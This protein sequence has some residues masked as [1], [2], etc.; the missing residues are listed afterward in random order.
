MQVPSM[1]VSKR[2][3][4]SWASCGVIFLPRKL[5]TCGLHR[6]HRSAGKLFIQG[7][8]GLGGAKDKIEGIFHLHQAPVV[9][10]V[11]GLQD[12]AAQLSVTVEH[13]MQLLGLERIRKRLRPPPVGCVTV[14]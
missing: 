11:E 14:S 4:I 13:L 9:A 2:E 6:Q 1:R 8:E 5:A 3:P 7:L 10:L 12:R